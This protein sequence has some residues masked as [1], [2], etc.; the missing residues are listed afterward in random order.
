MTT[1]S[2]NTTTLVEEATKLLNSVN[3][4]L[5]ALPTDVKSCTDIELGTALSQIKMTGNRIRELH[6]S[7]NNNNNAVGGTPETIEDLKEASELLL[8][9]LDEAS[10]LEVKFS[11]ESDVRNAK[12]GYVEKRNAFLQQ[13]TA[14]QGESLKKALAMFVHAFPTLAEVSG[15]VTSNGGMKTTT[16]GKIQ[17]TRYTTMTLYIVQAGEETFLGLWDSV[18]VDDKLTEQEANDRRA[19]AVLTVY[20]AMILVDKHSKHIAETA[21]F[22]R[23]A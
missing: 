14:N 21:K 1:Q 20:N 18:K 9:A 22:I 23:K 5:D 13:S 12:R 7:M 10:V 6:D 16:A 19:S 17:E 11:A 8:N 2:N 15:I 4:V 3:P